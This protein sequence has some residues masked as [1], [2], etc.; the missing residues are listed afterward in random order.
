[1]VLVLT[2]D[3]AELKL[4]FAFMVDSPIA[5]RNSFIL[6]EV[7]ITDYLNT[8]LKVENALFKGIKLLIAH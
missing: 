5:L 6:V 4:E 1:M 8:L 2:E 3:G 7:G